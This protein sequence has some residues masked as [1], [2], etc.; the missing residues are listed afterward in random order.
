MGRRQSPPAV[1]CTG[2]ALT[3]VLDDWEKSGWVKRRQG[4]QGGGWQLSGLLLGLE[5]GLSCLEVPGPGPCCL[6]AHP[7]GTVSTPPRSDTHTTHTTHPKHS[8]QDRSGAPHPLATGRLPP[9]QK[10]TYPPTHHNPYTAVERLIHYWSLPQEAPA[11]KPEQEPEPEWPEAGRIEYSDVWMRYRPELDPVL[12]GACWA[13]L[14]LFSG[15]YSD[16]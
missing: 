3:Q 11:K 6:H 15:G 14:L 9:P 13:V 2:C 16:I 1:P 5:A 7:R 8:H 12:R 10:V 4:R